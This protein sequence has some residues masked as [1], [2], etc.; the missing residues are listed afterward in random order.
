MA[1]L[2]NR[3][4]SYRN[5]RQK[6]QS[7][8]NTARSNLSS[9]NKMRSQSYQ[10]ENQTDSNSISITTT[11]PPT[12]EPTRKRKR[13]RPR[14]SILG[15][16]SLNEI[17]QPEPAQTNEPSTATQQQLQKVKNMNKENEIKTLKN[18]LKVMKATSARQKRANMKKN[19]NVKLVNDELKNMKKEKKNK[20]LISGDIRYLSEQIL[21]AMNCSKLKLSEI[22]LL[23]NLSDHIQQMIIKQT[24]RKWNNE[25]IK[26]KTR[27]KYENDIIR[28]TVQKIE[29]FVSAQFPEKFCSFHLFLFMFL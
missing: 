6:Q 7:K 27:K 29:H 5:Y 21:V 15:K 20:K 24:L 17:S 23:S 9:Y 26:E 28:N 4:E 11:P 22:K 3:E 8:R 18:K 12:T 13:R 2:N 14:R 16:R 25:K 10:S 1:S 19:E